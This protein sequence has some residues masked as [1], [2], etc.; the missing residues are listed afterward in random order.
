MHVDKQKSL[1]QIFAQVKR[2]GILVQVILLAA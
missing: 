1:T 2:L